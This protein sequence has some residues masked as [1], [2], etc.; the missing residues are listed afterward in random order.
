M[1]RNKAFVSDSD[2]KI[3]PMRPALSPEAREQQMIA[4][5][6]DE[7]ERRIRAGTASSQELCHYLKLGTTLSKLEKEKLETENKLLQAKIAS[8]EAQATS[9]NLYSDALKAFKTYHGDDPSKEEEDY[10]EY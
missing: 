10:D 5:A 7:V 4:L 8:L 9:A 1:P 3:Q 6:T 2:N